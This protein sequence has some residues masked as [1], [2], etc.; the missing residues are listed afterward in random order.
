MGPN[1]Q[2]KEKCVPPK[3]NFMLCHWFREAQD[4][5]SVI[6]TKDGG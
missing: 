3:C 5:N 1:T 2:I 4:I 6:F